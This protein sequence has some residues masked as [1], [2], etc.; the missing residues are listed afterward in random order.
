MYVSGDRVRLEPMTACVRLVPEHW[1]A[2]D[3]HPGIVKHL[4]P[5]KCYS[6]EISHNL[7]E[8]A[9]ASLFD[10]WARLYWVPEGQVI[11]SRESQIGFARSAIAVFMVHKRWWKPRIV[12]KPDR[13]EDCP[14]KKLARGFDR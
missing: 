1:K 2:S 12:D 8:G 14:S 3:S 7:P 6:V 10:L 11:P 13:P 9:K 4:P 5:G